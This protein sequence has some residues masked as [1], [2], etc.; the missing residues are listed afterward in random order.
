M[1]VRTARPDLW[2]AQV[3]VRA[4][5]LVMGVIAA[6]LGGR[7]LSS[8]AQVGILI[9]IALVA[10]IPVSARWVV[11]LAEA[12]AVAS[13]AV[14]A[15]GDPGP[16]LPYLLV[17]PIVT[18]LEAGIAGA[19]ATTGATAAVVIA[20]ELLTPEPTPRTQL[21]SVLWIAGG[22]ACGVA[23]SYARQRWLRQSPRAYYLVANRLLTE[24][25][26]IARQLPGG[27]D[28][29]SLAQATLT[30]LSAV[31]PFDRG[32]LYARLDSGSLVPLAEKGGG[33]LAWNAALDDGIWGEAWSSGQPATAEGVFGSVGGWCVVLPLNVGDRR[34]GLVALQRGGGPWSQRE[35]DEA[36]S[37]ADDGALRL[38]TGRLFSEVRALATVEERRRL[39]R[40]IHDGIAQEVAGLGFVV[41]DLV[42]RT[43]DPRQRDDLAALR[44]DLTR[45]VSDLRLS[46]F[47]LR[48]DVEHDT[49]L[50]AALS[51]YVRSV[52]TDSGLTVH[53]VL[54]ESTE[55]FSPEVESEL[56]RIAQEAIVN[57]RKHAR[58]RNL[59]VTCRVAPPQAFLR[60]ADDG[61]GLGTARADSFGIEIMRERAT[62]VG[63]DL[64]I[65]PRFGGGTV[66]EVTMGDADEPSAGRGVSLSAGGPD[67][68]Q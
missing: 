37:L 1:T 38:Q 24:L 23:A 68:A 60:I 9:V 54:D 64:T 57:T 49:G 17:P 29:V 22:L 28:E 19:L 7:S 41:D 2:L 53:L 11:H 10:S 63:A 35:I 46:I 34:S 30:D 6:L 14:I 13:V 67:R 66:V 16:T 4:V 61:R 15:W 51:S 20:G 55:R 56:L 21:D 39:A 48:S 33:R 12:F 26:S 43:D 47:D 50:G 25:R 5:A 40:E 42:A 27:L 44:G 45:L 8:F 62:R 58:A 59:W 36:Q 65:R 32:V 31:I 18:A 3:G 52:G